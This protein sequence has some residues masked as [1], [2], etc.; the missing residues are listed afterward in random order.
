MRTAKGGLIIIF[1]V[2]GQEDI[3]VEAEEQCN[4]TPM[5]DAQHSDAQR[6]QDASDKSAKADMDTDVHHDDY[7]TGLPSAEAAA[8]KALTLSPTTKAWLLHG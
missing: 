1:C 4:P 8:G 5:P 2:A 7:M 6:S 3:A